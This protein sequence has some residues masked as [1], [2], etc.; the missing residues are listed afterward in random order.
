MKRLSLRQLRLTE[1]EDEMY[2]HLFQRLEQ[3]CNISH[4]R[5]SEIVF[6]GFKEYAENLLASYIPSDTQTKTQTSNLKQKKAFIEQLIEQI[7]EDSRMFLTDAMNE[8]FFGNELFDND[9]RTQSRWFNTLLSDQQIVIFYLPYYFESSNASDFV[10]IHKKSKWYPQLKE[11]FFSVKKDFLVITNRD[12]K[13]STYKEKLLKALKYKSPRKS[14]DN[15][16]KIIFNALLFELNKIPE[17]PMYN[18]SD[19]IS[20]EI[21]QLRSSHKFQEAALLLSQH[22]ATS[23]KAQEKEAF[24]YLEGLGK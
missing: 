4:Q 15:A 14:M 3:E 13:F 21:I 1:K 11:H 22:S 20:Q 6:Q 18:Q 17:K 9:L 2:E 7:K 10:L 16:E 5:R 23:S 24:A 8:L 12:L 19:Y